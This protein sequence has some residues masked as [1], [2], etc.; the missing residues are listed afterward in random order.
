MIETIDLSDLKKMLAGNESGRVTQQK[1][2]RMTSEF[3]NK[4]IREGK[5]LDFYSRRRK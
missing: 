3:K 5:A 1:K 2:M 4:W